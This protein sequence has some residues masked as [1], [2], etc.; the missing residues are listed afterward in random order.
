MYYVYVL[1]GNS[2]PSFYIG[3]SSNLRDRVAQHNAGKVTSTKRG[4][5]WTVAYYEAYQNKDTA[6]ARE[7]R[8]KQRGR[9]WQEIK[10]RIQE[11]N[12]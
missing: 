10:K 4:M 6:Q 2:N 12:V 9:A 3:Y 8:L 7:K 11:D 5:P 1:K